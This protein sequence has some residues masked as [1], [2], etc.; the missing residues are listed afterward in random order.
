MEIF[1]APSGAPWKADKGVLSLSFSYG[2]SI[3]YYF[4]RIGF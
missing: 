3:A 1:P 4:L 2:A